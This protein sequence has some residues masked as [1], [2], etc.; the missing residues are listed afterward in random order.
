MSCYDVNIWMKLH[1]T[2][3]AM[4]ME[5]CTSPDEYLTTD[6]EHISKYVLDK[7]LTSVQTSDRKQSVTH[8][9]LSAYQ[10]SEYKFINNMLRA[11][12]NKSNNPEIT[13]HFNDCLAS[14]HDAFMSD[15]ELADDVFK[16]F[17]EPHPGSYGEID[18][19]LRLEE[20]LAN[21]SNSRYR[22]LLEP[23]AK[24]KDTE[25]G[26]EYNTDSADVRRIWS[27][28]TLA[29]KL[30]KTAYISF[31][32]ERISLK[33]DIVTYRGVERI[34][35]D[36]GESLNK[37][38]IPKVGDILQDPAFTS[39][40]MSPNIVFQFAQMPYG[41]DF[42]PDVHSYHKADMITVKE[43]L[44]P[45]DWRRYGIRYKLPAG[46]HVLPMKYRG[47]VLSEREILLDRNQKFKIVDVNTTAKIIT[48]E[49]VE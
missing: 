11:V 8:P 2:A 27:K 26:L 44:D 38:W 32:L 45:T 19:Q 23:I 28:H 43:H 41:D 3:G 21:L 49:P 14:L 35:Y 36:T 7:E 22:P 39:T 10:D 24:F 29:S 6:V 48:V 46:S 12:L 25:I 34:D 31:V 9:I 5:L 30:I 4:F 18:I 33:H 16:L 15:D 1:S 47:L 40:S 20:E 42:N 17:D 37:G 13:K